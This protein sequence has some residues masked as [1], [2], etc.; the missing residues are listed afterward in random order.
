MANEATLKKYKKGESGNPS[1]R[2]KGA[3]S[4]KTIIKDI[5]NERLSDEMF[6]EIS[7]KYGLPQGLSQGEAAAR[8]CISRII[9]QGDYT[10]LAK[11]AEMAGEF[12]EKGPTVNIIYLDKQDA[13][14]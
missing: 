2:P 1:G 10:G 14:L 8:K 3:K 11:I 6:Q 5:L 12:E 4:L 13:G 7:K 9:E